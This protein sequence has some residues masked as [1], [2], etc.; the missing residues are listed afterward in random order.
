MEKEV[1]IVVEPYR[2]PSDEFSGLI[3]VAFSEIIFEPELLA[4]STITGPLL[5]DECLLN[6]CT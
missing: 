5:M 1:E 3:A 4:F 2:W 6:A